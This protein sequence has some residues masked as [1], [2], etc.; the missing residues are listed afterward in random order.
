M[1]RSEFIR[2]GLALGMGLPFLSLLESCKKEVKNGVPQF[3]IN[4]SGK[5]IIIGAGASG[6]NGGLPIASK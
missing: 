1:K 2:Q 6:L 4:F 5:V 3:E